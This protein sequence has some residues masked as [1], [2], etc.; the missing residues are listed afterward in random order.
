M[1]NIIEKRIEQEDCPEKIKKVLCDLLMEE[2]CHLRRER[3]NYKKFYIQTI[4]KHIK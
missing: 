2:S 3:W 4:D 1:Q